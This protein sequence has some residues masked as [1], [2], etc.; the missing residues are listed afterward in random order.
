MEA[1]E[2]DGDSPQ[3]S[4]VPWGPGEGLTTPPSSRVQPLASPSAHHAHQ[5]GQGAD[6]GSW[7]GSRVGLSIRKK[8]TEAG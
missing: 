1:G 4:C 8:D 3:V 6:T 5:G 2:A 7:Q